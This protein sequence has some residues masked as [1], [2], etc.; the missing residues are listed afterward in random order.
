MLNGQRF[1]KSQFAESWG[2]Q[3][4]YA[5]VQGKRL[6]Y[7][8]YDTVS[9]HGG[10]SDDMYNRY[11]PHWVDKMGYVIDY[12]HLGKYDPNPGLAS[13]VQALMQQRGCDISVAL[14][15][16]YPIYEY[17]VI[18]EWFKSKGVYKTTVYPLYE[19]NTHEA[20][21]CGFKDFGVTTT[22]GVID[23]GVM[24]ETAGIQRI[25]KEFD[26]FDEKSGNEWQYGSYYE[27]NMQAVFQFVH[28]EFPQPQGHLYKVWYVGWSEK[29]ESRIGF[30]GFVLWLGDNNIRVQ[31]LALLH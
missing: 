15:A 31:V 25:V 23:L 2:E 29:Y 16:D 24:S 6:H 14:I 18:N 11:I 19:Y 3:G 13:S 30:A 26:D 4:G 21:L 8:L 9:Y 10:K 12:D 17:I 1:E 5:V 28:N 7:W 22:R 20:Y 27:T